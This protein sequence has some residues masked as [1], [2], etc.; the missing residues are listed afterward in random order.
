MENFIIKSSVDRQ[1]LYCVDFGT[2]IEEPELIL[3]LCHGMQ[4]HIF[5]YEEIARYLEKNCI[6]VVGMD[7]RGHGKTGDDM[8]ILGHI[9]DDKGYYKLPEDVNDLN[10]FLHSKYPNSK[11]VILGHSMGSIIVRN[12]L[13]KYSENVDGAIICG[14]VGL[15]K[16]VHASGLT[17]A[18]L[19]C[20]ITGKR[21]KLKF[22]NEIPFKKHN[23]KFGKVKTKVDWLC[24]D[25]NEV[26]KYIEDEYCGF[27]CTNGFYVDLLTMVKNLSNKENVSKINKDLPIFFI[28]GSMDPVGE[29]SDGVLESYELFRE[30]G[31]EDVSIKLYPD[32]RH[33][34]FNEIGREEVFKDVLK[35]LNRI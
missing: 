10:R 32:M 29:Y 7:N 25:E 15:F 9:S 12:F 2:S 28:S 17:L 27:P 22:I 5:R 20:K 16:P 24:R 35:F 21:K 6:K 34:I 26:Q 8:G 11:L 18:R 23:S 30:V 13:N 14:T 4:E 31:I 19:M 1:N 3:Q 33:E